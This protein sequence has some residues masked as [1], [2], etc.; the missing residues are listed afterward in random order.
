MFNI[1]DRIVHPMHGAGVIESIEEK[2]VLGQRQ[3]YY[4][5]KMPIGNLKVMIPTK[6]IQDIGIREV[7]T[8]RDADRVFEELTGYTDNKKNSWSKRYRENLD[9]IRGGD[10]FEVAE[11][12][13][14]LMIRDKEKG[15]ST[16][17]KKM[18]NSAKQILISELV[19]AKGV[20][21]IDIE[22]RIDAFLK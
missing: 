12:V 13:K 11:V 8:L 18:L 1:G 6:N 22:Q 16:G 10:V 9:K 7:V 5:M 21:P 17:E 4:I 2:E 15:L 14:A 19:L 3:S 20:N